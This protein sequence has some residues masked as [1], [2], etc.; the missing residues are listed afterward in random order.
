MKALLVGIQTKYDRYDIEYSLNELKA[1][2]EVLDYEVLGKITQSLDSPNSKT[3]IGKGKL[4]ELVIQI[5][6]YDI[7]I[8]IFNDEL[9]P[10]QLK[11]ISDE[12]K[13]EVIDRTF[14]ILKIFEL[15]AESSDS[16]LEIK[17]AK[18]LYLLPRISSM[19]IG[20]SR[21]GGSGIT[22]GSGETQRELDR[23]HLMAEIN[24]IKAEIINSKKMKENQI[25]RIKRN[26]LPIVC[27]VGYTNSGKSTTMNTLLDHLEISDNKKVLAKDQLF[28]TLSTFKRKISYKKN[29]FIL[30]DT[31]GFV[32][33]LPHHL[34]N[35]FYETLQE[36]KSA[37]LIIH[38][39]D[40]SSPY[41]N[42]QARVI[43]EVL[44][45]LNAIN[46]P[47][48]YVLNK[49]DK[50][51]DD[52]IY[53]PGKKTIKYSNVTKQG[54]DELLDSIYEEIAKSTIH[55]RVTIPYSSGDLINMI[56]K[57]ATIN[58]RE[59]LDNGTYY[60]IELPQKYY[61]LIKDYD[62]D[63]MVS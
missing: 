55:A 51:I 38:V 13:V 11:N 6:A 61:Y 23:R 53:V 41:I 57:N 8:V 34:V 40:S 29:D 15:H 48:I 22:R 49:W 39:I 59:Y 18:N 46:I 26:E 24:H 50:T 56:E 7:D 19:H 20:Q 14:L 62:I 21:I 36:V 54:L 52:T 63:M 43:N 47:T 5:N 16:K 28:A 1:L 25:S 12:L 3:Y 4:S 35:S 44:L 60:D 37:D 32:S 58:K 2:A 45:S 10:S 31:I 33:K 17:L 42:E 27:L 9:S 30:V